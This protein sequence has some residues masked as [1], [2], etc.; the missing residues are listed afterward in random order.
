MAEVSGPVKFGR[1]KWDLRFSHSA[2][3]AVESVHGSLFGLARKLVGAVGPMGFT[4]PISMDTGA[5]LVWAGES[6][7]QPKL[8]LAKT[9]RRLEAMSE[10][11]RRLLMTWAVADFLKAAVELL[12]PEIAKL[13]PVD[14][15][16]E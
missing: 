9:K 4:A 12:E 5:L 7:R 3:R 2:L 10:L 1:W 16:D 11:E 8:T 15:D 6:W 14:E 13:V